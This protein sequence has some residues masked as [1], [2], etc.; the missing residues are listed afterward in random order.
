MNKKIE[1]Y[2]VVRFSDGTYFRKNGVLFNEKTTSDIIEATTYAFDWQIHKDFYLQRYLHEKN[3]TYE[4]IKVKVAT[5]ME[6]EV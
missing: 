1:D 5:T 4:V 2:L 3:L 6:I